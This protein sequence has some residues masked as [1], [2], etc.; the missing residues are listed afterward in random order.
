MSADSQDNLPYR[1]IDDVDDEN[2]RRHYWACA[3]GL[4]AVDGLEV[5][6]YLRE[7]A[8]GHIAGERTLDEAGELIRSYHGVGAG[9]TKAADGRDEIGRAHV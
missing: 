6:P 5:S 3:I 4:Q 9:A 1:R 7:V 8:R 2:A